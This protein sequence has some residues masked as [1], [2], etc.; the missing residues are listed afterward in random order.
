MANRGPCPTSTATAEPERRHLGE[1]EVDEDDLTRQH[2]EAEVGVNRDDDE[3]GDQ[4]RQEEAQVH[5]CAPAANAVASPLTHEL[6]RS[7]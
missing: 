7:K 6:M 1:R 5:Q 4:R 2:V 3:A